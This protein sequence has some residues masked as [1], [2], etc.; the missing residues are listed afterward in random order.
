MLQVL[1]HKFNFFSG[2]I[3]HKDDQVSKGQQIL[4]VPGPT[5]Q[6]S[7]TEVFELL[8]NKL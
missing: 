5:K 1:F 8:M 3:E 7:F 6:H 2:Q 4:E